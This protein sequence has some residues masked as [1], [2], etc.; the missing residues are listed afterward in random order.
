MGQGKV[1]SDILLQNSKAKSY[2]IERCGEL[3]IR[4]V[5]LATYCNVPVGKFAQWVNAVSEENMLIS[6][7]P[8]EVMSMYEAVAIYPVVRF[9]VTSKDMMSIEQLGVI[10][11]IKNMN[12]Q[13]T[14]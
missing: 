1:P 12:N 11:I 4:P 9:V 6:L 14:N 13:N 5:D 7:T 2:L 8:S 3:G 10:D